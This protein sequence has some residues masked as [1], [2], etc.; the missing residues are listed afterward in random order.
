MTGP[1]T[2]RAGYVERRL[3]WIL[4]HARATAVRE[5]SDPATQLLSERGQLRAELMGWIAEIRLAA[6]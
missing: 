1:R 6:P 3:C 5:S 2:R 4:D